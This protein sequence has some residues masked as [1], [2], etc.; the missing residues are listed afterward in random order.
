MNM[1]KTYINPTI[2]VVKIQTTGMLAVSLPKGA[3]DP[4]GVDNESEVLGRDFDFDDD[5]EY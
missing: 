2:E 4:D 3:T 1:K 5:E